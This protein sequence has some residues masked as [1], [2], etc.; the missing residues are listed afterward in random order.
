MFCVVFYVL[1]LLLLIVLNGFLAMSELAVMSSNKTRLQRR[2]Q[3]DNSNAAAALVL[4]RNPHR[5]LA[6]VQIGITLIGVLSGAF[7]GASLAGS[8]AQKLAGLPY[9]G[10]YSSAIAMALVVSAITYLSLLAELIPKRI[11]VYAPESIAAA[12]A[13]PMAKLSTLASPI[14]HVLSVS[15]DYALRL[16]GFTQMKQTPVTEEEIRILIDQATVAGVL[17]EAEQDMVERVFRLGDR[18]VGVMMTPRNEVVWLDM[19]ESPEK[20][21]RKIARFPYSRFP[22]GQKAGSIQGV[23]H[24]RDL[25]VRCLAGKPFDLR[26]SMHKPIFV[27]EGANA[28]KALESFRRSGLQ[29]AVVVDEY[30]TIEGIITLTDILEAVVGDIATP[31]MPEEPQILPKE[32]NVWL[33]DGMLPIDELMAF[34]TIPKLPGGRAGLFRTVGGFVMSHLKRVP[35]EGDSFECCGYGFEVIEMEGRRVRRVLIKKSTVTQPCE[36]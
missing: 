10:P 28:L 20:T 26:A 32:Q 30:G 7:G 6:T 1:V 5:F 18:R 15:T 35:V 34:L 33:V 3:E 12:I 13:K 25:A 23:V 36:G 9:V 19:N 2:A 4:A 11:A 14:I 27:H 31:E 16:L 29:L 24:V 22:V 8:L 21:R 17:E